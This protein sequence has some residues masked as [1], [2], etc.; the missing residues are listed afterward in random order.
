[1]HLPASGSGR[2]RLPVRGSDRPRSPQRAAHG[3]PRSS[4]A[5]R[6]SGMVLLAPVLIAHQ[7]V[8]SAQ[9]KRCGGDLFLERDTEEVRVFCLQ[10]S[11]VYAQNLVPLIKKPVSKRVYAR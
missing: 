2:F 1:M 11:A 8:D 6:R 7:P 9:C 3:S 10:C 4:P 5:C